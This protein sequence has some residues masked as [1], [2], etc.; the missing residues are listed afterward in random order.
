MPAPTEN[1]GIKSYPVSYPISSFARGGSRNIH[2]TQHT[3]DSTETGIWQKESPQHH[4]TRHHHGNNRK[5]L[6][7]YSS[8]MQGDSPAVL[9]PTPFTLAPDHPMRDIFATAS[10]GPMTKYLSRRTRKRIPFPKSPDLQTSEVDESEE[11]VRRIV[12]ENFL[13]EPE[14]Q[15]QQRRRSYGSKR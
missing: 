11:G 7:T 8:E 12:V 9:T 5:G 13:T 2:N 10:T 14:A 1:G 3:E 15:T 4:R 6:R